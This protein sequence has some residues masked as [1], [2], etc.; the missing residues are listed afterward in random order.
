MQYKYNSMIASIKYSANYI[1]NKFAA[2]IKMLPLST[3]LLKKFSS[4]IKKKYAV[5]YDREGE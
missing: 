4:Y 1:Y 3:S 2:L 5:S